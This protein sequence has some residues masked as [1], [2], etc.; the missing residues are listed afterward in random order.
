VM[1]AD[2]GMAGAPAAPPPAADTCGADPANPGDGICPGGLVCGDPTGTMN[3]ACMCPNS[4]TMLPPCTMGGPE[5]Q[6]FPGTTC[7]NLFGAMGC[8]TSC[9]PP[10]VAPPSC[11]DPLQ[12]A[13]PLGTGVAFCVMAG[14]ITPPPCAVQEDC[15]MYE[16]TFCMD[17][18]ALGIL[19]CVKSCAL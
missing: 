6:G 1:P 19:G 2:Q 14:Q 18:L 13:D 8:H 11:P 5:C 17:P 15:A 7:S 4:P 10:G 12:C 16:G 9:T 3:Y